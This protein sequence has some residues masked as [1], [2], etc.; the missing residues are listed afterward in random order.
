[1][2]RLA[3]LCAGLKIDKMA[4]VCCVPHLD[5]G[6]RAG[7]GMGDWDEHADHARRVLALWLRILRLA[8]FRHH[9][10]VDSAR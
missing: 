3:Q 9:A 6:D 8:A 7:D 5:R 10:P 1:M 2:P 4:P